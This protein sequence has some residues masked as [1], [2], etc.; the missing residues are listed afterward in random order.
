MAEFIL[1]FGT[2]IS[3]GGADLPWDPLERYQALMA[4]DA[5]EEAKFPRQHVLN[6]L[7]DLPR[8]GSMF[9]PFEQID[10]ETQPR[11]Q[12]AQMAQMAQMAQVRVSPRF[13][14][15]KLVLCRKTC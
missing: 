11:N 14:L 4:V 13:L 15:V 8:S 12:I 5:L 7:P 3:L 2:E 10:C 6:M 9:E 1:T